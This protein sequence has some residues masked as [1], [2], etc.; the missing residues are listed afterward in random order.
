MQRQQDR[1][2]SIPLR[3]RKPIPFFAYLTGVNQPRL[4]RC[5]RHLLHHHKEK[6]QWHLQLRKP[7]MERFQPGSNHRSSVLSK[8]AVTMTFW[9]SRP[10]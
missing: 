9:P 1:E 7:A 4:S 2:L 3:F 6:K 8:R 5:M 10:L